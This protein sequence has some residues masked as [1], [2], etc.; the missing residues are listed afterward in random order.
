MV[1]VLFRRKLDA[2]QLGFAIGE[3]LAHVQHL[4]NLGRL[5]R[6]MRA[7]GVYTYRRI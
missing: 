4:V 5:S 3:T 6:G 1:P 2:H 7:D